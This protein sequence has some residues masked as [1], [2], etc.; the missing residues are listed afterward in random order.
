[1]VTLF[2]R[3]YY[4]LT[5]VL[6]CLTT[7]HLHASEVVTASDE[8]VYN[9]FLK[10]DLILD[11]ALQIGNLLSLPVLG[12]TSGHAFCSYPL[13]FQKIPG[14]SLSLPSR[15]PS[16]LP[17]ASSIIKAM[18]WPS[19]FLQPTTYL[20]ACLVSSLASRSLPQMIMFSLPLN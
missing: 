7:G 12:D 8:L 5:F 14:G 9:G 2:W 17:L 1:M 13:S 19:C 20:T 18:A 6:L 3:Y 4:R 15:Q 16:S 10:A 11:G